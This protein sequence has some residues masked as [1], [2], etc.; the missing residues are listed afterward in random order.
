MVA[1]WSETL[2][3]ESSD[4]A[5]TSEWAVWPSVVILPLSFLCLMDGFLC[6]SFGV[7]GMRWGKV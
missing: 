5:P 2:V 6:L 1:S 7:P 3:L 4:Q